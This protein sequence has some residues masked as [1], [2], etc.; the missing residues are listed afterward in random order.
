M[1]RSASGNQAET[2]TK[3]TGFFASQWL[4]RTMLTVGLLTSLAIGFVSVFALIG[5]VVNPLSIFFC[6]YQLMFALMLIAAELKL[7]FFIRWFLFLAPYIGLGLFYIF[8]AIFTI[9][10]GS[11]WQILVAAVCGVIGLIY[12]F[13]GFSGQDR[14]MYLVSILHRCSI[15]YKFGSCSL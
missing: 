4:R 3:K 13:M 1:S 2:S 6:A 14:G 9:G 15:Y 8:V 11:W 5:S 10:N 12:I 7:K